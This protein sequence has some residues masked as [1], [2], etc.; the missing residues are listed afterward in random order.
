MTMVPMTQMTMPYDDDSIDADTD[1]DDEHGDSNDDDGYRAC[2]GDTCFSVLLRESASLEQS[3]NEAGTYARSASA[4]EDNVPDG[5]CPWPLPNW[6]LPL[7]DDNLYLE[8]D[9]VGSLLPDPFVRYA[10]SIFPTRVFSS[11]LF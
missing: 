5:S 9:I 11:E 10:K 3:N 7:R 4:V 6:W 2:D 8:F 1:D